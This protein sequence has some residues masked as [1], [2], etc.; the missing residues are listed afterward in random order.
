MRSATP[1]LRRSATPMT[2]TPN[3]GAER[4]AGAPDADQ[5]TD[6]TG[7][8]PQSP[9]DPTESSTPTEGTGEAFV[10]AF[11]P[12]QDADDDGGFTPEDYDALAA[13]VMAAEGQDDG[14]ED[15]PASAREARYRQRLRAA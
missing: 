1:G 8:A 3:A 10:D 5:Q 2:E 4:A 9:S 14:D 13:E 6:D 7:E 11:T 12:A 15:E